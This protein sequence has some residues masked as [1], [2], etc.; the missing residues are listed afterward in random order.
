MRNARAEAV[1]G[2]S[3]KRAANGQ[4]ASKVSSAGTM[5]DQ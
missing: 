3:W 4:V 1:G 2:T 5:R